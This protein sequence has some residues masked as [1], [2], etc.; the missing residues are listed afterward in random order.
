MN[1]IL[2]YVLVTVTRNRDIDEYLKGCTCIKNLSDDLVVP[3]DEIRQR[4]HQLLLMTK[5]IIDLLLLYQQPLIY[6]C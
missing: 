4:F 1:G 6:Y 2:A 3:C 5:Q